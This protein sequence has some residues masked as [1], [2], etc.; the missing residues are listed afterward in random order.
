M[1]VTAPGGLTAQLGGK[2]KKLFVIGG[3]VTG[4]LVF[5]EYR[6]SRLSA[7]V[8]AGSVDPGTGTADTGPGDY[9]DPYASDTSGLFG[10][11][12]PGGGL[13]GAPGTAAAN[14]PVTNA[15]WSQLVQQLLVNDGF[16]PVSV[17]VAIGHFLAGTA[18]TLDQDSIR[19][20]AIALEGPPPQ[21]A[22]PVK[23]SPATPGGTTNPTVPADG[24]YILFPQRF[25]YQV[26]G[27]KRYQLSVKTAADMK[28]QG[29]KLNTI[30]ANNPVMKLPQGTPYVI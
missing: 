4:G 19:Q 3:L 30:L 26:L 17:S 28:K 22:P 18:M 10:Y 5:W 13:G 21:G 1:V 24:Y 7:S 25:Q 14:I 11:V 6:K 9:T 20:A 12:Q 23:L 2:N 15:Q 29:V 8:P 16:D 27:G